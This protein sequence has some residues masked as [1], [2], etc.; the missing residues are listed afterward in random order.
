MLLSISLHFLVIVLISLL[1]VVLLLIFAV[2]I[3][4]LVR[5]RKQVSIES[6]SAEIDAEIAEAIVNGG[7]V[8][9][10]IYNSALAQQRG[11]RRLM[12]EKLISAEKKFSGGAGL[13]IRS[14]FNDYGLEKESIGKLGQ[15]RTHLIAGG[16][17]ELTAMRVEKALP[18]ISRLLHHPSPQVYQ[19][20]QYSVVTFNGFEGLHFLNDAQGILS[21]WQQL[22]LLN[23]IPAVPPDSE[24]MLRKWLHSMNPSV[25]VFV[26]R[27]IRK[28]QQL[29][30]YADVLALFSH[31]NTQIRLQAV[32]TL[33]TLENAE[34]LSDYILS[35]E[36]QPDE[37][38][39]EIVN[40][41]CKMSDLRAADFF[42]QKLLGND[43]VA[44]RI[45]AAK[46]LYGLGLSGELLSLASQSGA[47]A[48]LV[49]I[50][51]HVLQEKI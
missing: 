6:W 37:V 20:A 14:L 16:I 33:Q 51:K 46:G 43:F 17:L 27:I 29:N 2:L 15:K 45:G 39:A 38:K 23:S 47:P 4:G 40:S 7:E 10:R 22:R 5:Y 48:E 49:S 21:E 11:Y 35:Y 50:I 31:P 41:V 36:T 26:L 32:Q 42:R 8:P 30:M 13:I 1:A 24:D 18:A 44:V 9:G 12:L 25:T 19:E 3:Y 34:T 28:Y